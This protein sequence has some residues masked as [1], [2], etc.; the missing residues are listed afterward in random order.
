MAKRA[1]K[2]K[3]TKRS[4]PLA[5]S[6][7]IGISEAS[8]KAIVAGIASIIRLTQKNPAVTLEAIRAFAKLGEV[9]PVSIS[10]STFHSGEPR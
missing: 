9:G 10:N 6:L 7:N 3:T 5:P 4:T 2:R 8:A 1:K